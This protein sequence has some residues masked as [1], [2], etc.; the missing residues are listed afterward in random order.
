MKSLEAEYKITKIKAAVHL[1]A[2]PDPA[3]G[4]VREFE[5]KVVRTGWRSLVK[6]AQRYAEEKRMKLDLQHHKPIGHTK[7]DEVVGKQKIG[8][9]AKKAAQSRRNEEIEEQK[10]QGKLMPNRWNE[11][12]LDKDCF[13]WMS[14]W[15]TA[16]TH[17]VAGI[18]ELYRQLLTTKIY[19]ARKT[20]TG[21]EHDVRC[22]LCGKDQ[23]SV[24][25]VLSGCS[26]LAQT[27]YPA[28]HNAT[29]KILFLEVVKVHNLVEATLPWFSPA[30]P[31]P[32]YESDQVTIYCGVP[33]YAEQTVV[34]VNRIDARFVDRGSKTVTL[35]EMRCPWVENRR[36][37][38]EEKTGKYAPLRLELKQQHPGYEVRQYNIIIDVLGGYSKETTNWVRNLVSLLKG[39]CEKDAKISVS[40]SLNIARTFKIVC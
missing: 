5:E 3:M 8:E 16:P 30:Q 4:L 33:I 14:E 15:K 34:R 1:Y 2:N 35:L 19:S 25:H 10:W 18:H 21:T 6:D 32:T 26:A 9:W 20:R 40:S 23:E 38:E 37:K 31:K 39:R 17:T 24:A 28:R 36:Q 29:L 12:N 22:R 27:K 13:A 7:K 11:K